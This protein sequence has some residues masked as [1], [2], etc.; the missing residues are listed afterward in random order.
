LV[1][2]E[3]LYPFPESELRAELERPGIEEVVWLQEEPENMGAWW[4]M[5]H[6]L[7]RRR[8]VHGKF[9]YIG[10]VESSSPAE[11]YAADH[12]LVHDRILTA[13]TRPGVADAW[14]LD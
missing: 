2:V 6:Q 13:A 1:L 5:S 7:L 11:G 12:S 9:G 14:L 10:G 4:F 8:L 3:R